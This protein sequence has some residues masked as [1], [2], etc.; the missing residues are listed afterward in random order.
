MLNYIRYFFSLKFQEI[1]LTIKPNMSIVLYRNGHT[2][3]YGLTIP[4]FWQLVASFL[5]WWP[6]LD[7]RSSHA[8]FVV[9]EVALR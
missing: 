8:G 1:D 2:F 4:I 3:K 5:P 7:R 9:D 6:G